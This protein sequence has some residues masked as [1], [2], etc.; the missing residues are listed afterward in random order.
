M[1]TVYLQLKAVLRKTHENKTQDVK[2]KKQEI[3]AETAKV[4]FDHVDFTYA[5]AK[6]DSLTDI[7]L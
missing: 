5:G 7:S 3:S 4:E 2:E 6:S 1:W